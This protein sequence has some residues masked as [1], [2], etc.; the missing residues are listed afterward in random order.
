M[1]EFGPTAFVG[2]VTEALPVGGVGDRIVHFEVETVLAGE[3]PTE[4]DV[5]TANNSAACG[6]EAAVG[7]RMAVF[8]SDNGGI[9]SASLCSVA[10]PEVAIAALGPG[11]APS[12]TPAQVNAAPFDWQA[13]WL[14]AGAVALIGGAYLLTRRRPI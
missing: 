13:V 8:A 6:I 10:D 14:G 12:G 1:L 4:V 11:T 5:T 3:V 2:T 9:L 7:S